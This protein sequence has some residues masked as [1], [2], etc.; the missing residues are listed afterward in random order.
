M[1]LKNLIWFLPETGDPRH[2]S[3]FKPGK[4]AFS[5]PTCDVQP[6]TTDL[7]YLLD[8]PLFYDVDQATESRDGLFFHP[9]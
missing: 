1:V 3:S 7:P 5:Q 4:T 8:P 2:P 9:F 6:S